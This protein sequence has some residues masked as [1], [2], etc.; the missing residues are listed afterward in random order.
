MVE[1]SQVGSVILTGLTL[2]MKVMKLMSMPLII[3]LESRVILVLMASMPGL[4][5]DE[6]TMAARPVM[7]SK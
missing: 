2:I 7:R 6:V 3:S 4:D 1:H 5:T